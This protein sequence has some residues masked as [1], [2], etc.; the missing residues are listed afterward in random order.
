MIFN[1]S[2]NSFNIKGKISG[3]QQIEYSQVR[4]K[5]YQN[6]RFIS[7]CDS[8]SLGNYKIS[9]LDNSSYQLIFIDATQ[10]DSIIYADTLFY[11][12]NS[13]IALDIT[14]NKK[15]NADGNTPI[16]Y[17]PFEEDV[18]TYDINSNNVKLIRNGLPFEE[19]ALCG[20][21]FE[22][23]DSKYG[24]TTI[25]F[26]DIIFPYIKQMTDSYNKPVYDYLT[27][28]NGENW[29]E[30]YS[31]D[32]DSLRN[33]IKKLQVQNLDEFKNYIKNKYKLTGGRAIV[34]VTVNK[35]G[36]LISY[37]VLKTSSTKLKQIISKEIFRLTFS[38]FDCVD[39]L[40][41]II[42]VVIKDKI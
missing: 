37:E 33:S 30:R 29:R 32:I 4:I 15:I 13:D 2:V 1:E 42:P 8:D 23:L 35:E 34:K 3:I 12:N 11:I 22:M 7:Y 26:G 10:S 39:K 9:N 41:I 6:N 24:F 14:L 18:A 19:E 38:L 5:V 25:N 28:R 36:K 17:L 40:D 27:K 20:K 31:Q 16:R 21:K